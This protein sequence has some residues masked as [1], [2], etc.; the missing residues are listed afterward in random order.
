MRANEQPIEEQPITN[1]R[2]FEAINELEKLVRTR[3]PDATFSVG[4]GQDDPEAIY[5][6]ATVDLVDTEPVVNLVIG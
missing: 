4:R 3:Y 2:V 5:V 1:P 6:Y